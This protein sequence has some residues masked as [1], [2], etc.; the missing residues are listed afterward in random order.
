MI[1][2]YVISA[3]IT[4]LLT[5][6]L[7]FLYHRS[8]EKT[9]E[10]SNLK[11]NKIIFFRIIGGTV[12]F[13][14]LLSI[15]TYGVW[16]IGNYVLLIIALYLITVP[17]LKVLAQKLFPKVWK[18]VVIGVW[19]F[20]FF[21]LSVAISL[22]GLLLSG[23]MHTPTGN[24]GTV[25]VLGCQVKGN[26][27]SLILSRR[28]DAAYD[29]LKKHPDTVCIASGGEGNDENISEALCIKNELVKRGIDENRIIVEDKSVDTDTNLKYSKDIIENNRLSKDVVIV[30]DN[31]HQFRAS[32]Y[33]KRYELNSSACSSHAPISLQIPAWIREMIGLVK[34]LIIK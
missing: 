13:F 8:L 32:L 19:V 25:L 5:I 24:E 9:T 6:L 18:K 22:F 23:T 11:K 26:S 34:Y 15:V 4:A 14:T 10:K 7:I 16:G 12:L 2:H 21:G 30:T 31:F 20:F 1:L 27:P 3:V 28:I 29:Y 33:S 17:E